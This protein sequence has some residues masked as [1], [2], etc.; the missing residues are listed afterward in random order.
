LWVFDPQSGVAPQCL[1]LIFANTNT[2]RLVWKGEAGRLYGVQTTPDPV[3]G[4]WTQINLTAGNTILA[5]NEEVEVH[6]TVPP[7][8]TRRFFRIFEAN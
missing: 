1:S 2:V 3:K 4:P 8:A 5:T 7:E 6:Y